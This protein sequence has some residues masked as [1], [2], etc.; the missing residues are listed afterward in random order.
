MFRLSRRTIAVGTGAIALSFALA[1]MATAQEG[2][3]SGP[4]RDITRLGGSTAF[5][6]RSPLTTV[7]SLKRMGNDPKVA[8]DLRTILGQAGMGG[9]TEAV[10]A[11]LAGANASVRGGLCSDST[12]A[13]GTIVECDVQRGQTLQWMAY[14][15]LGRGTPGLLRNIRWEGATPFRAYL[16]RVVADRRTYTFVVPMICGNLSLMDI[17]EAPRVVE[18]TPPP[19]PS[20][21]RI[22]AVIAEPPPPPPPPPPPS[23]P[24]PSPRP[25]PPPPA[26]PAVAAKTMPFFL[27]AL[28][29][30]D[31]RVRP[32]D[33]EAGRLTDW[34]QCSPLFGLK[35]GVA[36]VFD[37]KWEVA[38]AAGVAIS[39]VHDKDKVNKS[40]VFV[41]AELNKYLSGGSF[42]GTGLSLW[43]ITRSDTFTPAW[44]LHFGIPL[45]NHPAHPVYF[46]GEGR[47]FFDHIDD[48]SNNYQFW[49]GVR[50]H[51]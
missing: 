4:V 30:K 47:L 27:D 43:D 7:I 44:M 31:R 19:A 1:T 11:A 38:G 15:L 23:P 16:F 45:G 24:P 2:S 49:G 29:G 33:I 25:P 28:F 46:L 35:F 22:A 9:L 40:E 20:P 41:D 50:V 26:P 6:A 21:G 39:L 36:K 12:P 37:S 18:V 34:A 8:A 17:A 48:A 5:Y 13:E 10:T 32:A 14:R 3:A 51:F 42:L